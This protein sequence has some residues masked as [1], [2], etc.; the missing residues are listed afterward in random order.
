MPKHSWIPTFL[1]I[2][3]PLLPNIGYGIYTT[4][5]SFCDR[6]F[7][8]GPNRYRG[9]FY[10][11][12]RIRYGRGVQVWE[13]GE[14]Y[15]G[16]FNSNRMHGYGIYIYANGD[17]YDGDWQNGLKHGCS[18]LIIVGGEQYQRQW[19]FDIKAGYRVSNWPD[20][21]TYE[22][23]WTNNQPYGFGFRILPSER[24]E[25]DFERWVAH[26]YAVTISL[27]RPIY[28][29]HWNHGQKKWVRSQYL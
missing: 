26:G 15:R 25:G 21:S 6:L 14:T 22:G 19:R 11:L 27:T 20:G 10:G 1:K 9:T 28:R 12:A 17:V 8:K 13:N 23:H 24:F 7:G 18:K 3:N 29:G 4:G 5:G 16:G 2:P